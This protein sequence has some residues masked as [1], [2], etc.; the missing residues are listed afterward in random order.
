MFLF[1]N[2]ISDKIILYLLEQNK[3][4]DKL[5][6]TARYRQAE[7]LLPMIDRFLKK[8]KI[9]LAQIKG[10]LV[11]KGPGSFTGTRIG[12]STANALA[13][14]L[15]VPIIGVNQQL[16]QLNLNKIIKATNKF[17]KINRFIS[18]KP[19]YSSL[20]AITKQKKK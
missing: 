4:V 8:N 14:S 9:K 2:T 11:A 15:N 16:T 20:P 10:I 7:L 19:V 6:K 17:K 18:V 5:I 3:I 13:F 1:I 12:V